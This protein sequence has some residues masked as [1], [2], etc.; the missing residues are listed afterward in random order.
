MKAEETRARLY[1]ERVV[2][3]LREKDPESCLAKARALREGGLRVIEVTWTTPGAAKVVREIAREKESLAGAG[4]ILSVAAAEEAVEAGAVFLVSPVLVD[5]V[6][7]WAKPRGVVYIP[8]ALTPQEIHRAWEQGL[9]PVKVFP[10]CDV[11]GAAYLRHVLAPMPFLELCPTGGITPANMKSYFEAG[12][13]VVGLGESL[14]RP[15]GV[16][17]GDLAALTKLAAEVRAAVL[18]P[19]A[20]AKR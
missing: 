8:G 9:R 15:P 16:P 11:G 14:T 17:E 13:R 3:I 5:A 7:S 1:E 19:S 4:S 12:A 6:A 18:N 2:V 20:P 10:V